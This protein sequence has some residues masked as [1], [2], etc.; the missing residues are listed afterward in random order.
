MKRN[1]KAIMI[2]KGYLFIFFFAL[3]IAVSQTFKY[4]YFIKKDLSEMNIDRILFQGLLL[5]F[6]FLI[7]GLLLVRWYYSMKDKKKK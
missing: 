5:F 1:N 7:P 3:F 6:M 4:R 2:K